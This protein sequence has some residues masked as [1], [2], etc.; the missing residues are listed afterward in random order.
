MKEFFSNDAQRIGFTVD[1]G[2]VESG[3]DQNGRYVGYSTA[4]GTYDA[5]GS[6]IGS[7]GLLTRLFN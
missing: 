2:S 1:N 7:P 3:Y 4:D 5:N 6:R